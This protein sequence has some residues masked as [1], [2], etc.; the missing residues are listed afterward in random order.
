M[1]SRAL[2]YFVMAMMF[3][4]LTACQTAEAGKGKKK[5]YP[6]YVPHV[7]I[8]VLAPE[9][10]AYVIVIYSSASEKIRIN[11]GG[12][13]NVA[14]LSPYTTTDFYLTAKAYDKNDN[15]LGIAKHELHLYSRPT[16]S[17]IRPYVQDEWTIDYI[18]RPDPAPRTD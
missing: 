3:I 15:L 16:S 6:P 13:K 17:Y 18:D 5:S 12:T 2:L 10:V 11:Q 14:L 4:S 8:T 1:K 9:D 7:F